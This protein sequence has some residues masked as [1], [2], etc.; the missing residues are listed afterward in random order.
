MFSKERKFRDFLVKGWSFENCIKYI[1]ILNYQFALSNTATK[2][3]PAKNVT[4]DFE[5]I[6]GPSRGAWADHSCES[7]GPLIQI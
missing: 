6:P 5:L 4:T 7:R 1:I 2:Y 3:A